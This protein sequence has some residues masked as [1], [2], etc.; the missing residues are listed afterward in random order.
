MKWLL[1]LFQLIAWFHNR[2]RR[3]ID[4]LY[5]PFVNSFS[6]AR[7]QSVVRSVVDVEVLLFRLLTYHTEVLPLSGQ[8]S[9]HQLGG[10]QPSCSLNI[11][12]KLLLPLLF[13]NELCSLS[14]THT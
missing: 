13:V 5:F 2:N 14:L 9:L 8:L 7:N 12:C 6:H 10:G 3:F 11:F 1:Y 4:I